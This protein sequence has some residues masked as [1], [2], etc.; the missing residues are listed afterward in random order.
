MLGPTL[1]AW[2][3]EGAIDDQLTATI[4]QVEQAHL[5]LGPIELV[6]L[7]HSQPRHPP[8]LGGQCVTSVGQFLLLHEQLLACS[9]PLLRRPDSGVIHLVLFLFDFFGF[10]FDCPLPLF[11]CCSCKTC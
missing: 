2:F 3:E 8:T 9:F 11:V 4:E 7:L 1:H 10:H 5:A 6:L